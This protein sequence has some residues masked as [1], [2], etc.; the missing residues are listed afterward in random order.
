M[1]IGGLLPLSLSDFPAR[2]AAV[3]FAQGCNFRCPFCHNGEL[4]PMHPPAHTQMSEDD[5]FVTLTKRAARLDGVIVS[6]G[7]PTLQ[8]DL[9]DFFSRVRALGLETGIETNGSKP[10]VLAELISRRLVDFIAMDI[11]APLDVYPRLCGV[12][13]PTAP[14]LE[15]ITLIAESGIEHQFRTTHVPALLS[16]ADLDAIRLLVPTGSPHRIQPFVPA[17]ALDPKL[18]EG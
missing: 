5:L 6:G 9:S 7:E 8:P 14:I 15:S 4:I 3:V 1:H 13:F 2:V 12:D 18:R 16:E 17:N 11:K 10:D